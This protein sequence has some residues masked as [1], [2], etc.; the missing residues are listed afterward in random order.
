MDYNDFKPNPRG[1]R[2]PTEVE[3]VETNS[4]VRNHVDSVSDRDEPN[5]ATELT[6]S[7]IKDVVYDSL[8]PSIEDFTVGIVKGL[9]SM[10]TGGFYS[11]YSPGRRD[12]H[13]AYNRI[14]EERDRRPRDIRA[15]DRRDRDRERESP[16]RFFDYD[17]LFWQTRGQAERVLYEMERL[18]DEWNEVSIADLFDIANKTPE[19]DGTGNNYGWTDLTYA[20]VVYG[21][22]GY[23][24]LDLPKPKS[25]K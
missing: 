23:Y 10:F 16:R 4:R 9:F 6:N 8:L 25:L 20:K 3:I 24:Y 5:L 2:Q 17:E 14:Y 18:I 13:R 15:R 21:R 11:S 1:L 19:G 7:F 12:G 22:D